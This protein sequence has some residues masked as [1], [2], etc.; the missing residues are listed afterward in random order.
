MRRKQGF[1]FQKAIRS[2]VDKQRNKGIFEKVGKEIKNNPPKI[3]E[4]TREKFGAADAKKQRIAIL[5]SK[6][7]KKLKKK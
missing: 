3:L 2:H 6:A 7:G 5:L 1:D 4:H